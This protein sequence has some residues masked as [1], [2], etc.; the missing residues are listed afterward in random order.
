MTLRERMDALIKAGAVIQVA[1]PDDPTKAFTLASVRWRTRPTR[2]LWCGV[3]PEDQ[4]HVHETAYDRAG[5]V[6]DRDLAFYRGGE[7]VL[8]VCP[9]EESGEATDDI[10]DALA[11]WRAWLGQDENAAQFTSFFESA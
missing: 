5:A 2:L 1:F 9:Y 11:E 4:H 6:H 7:I 10:R 8:Y 3:F